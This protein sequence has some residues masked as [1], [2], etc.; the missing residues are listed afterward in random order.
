MVAFIFLPGLWS[1]EC[2]QGVVNNTNSNPDLNPHSQHAFLLPS[3]KIQIEANLSRCVASLQ[4]SWRFPGTQEG[5]G[6]STLSSEVPAGSDLLMIKKTQSWVVV[7]E[8]KPD[9]IK[10][11]SKDRRGSQCRGR[12]HWTQWTQVN[13]PAKKQGTG[14]VPKCLWEGIF[15][16]SR[17]G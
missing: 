10:R 6:A 15:A 7:G 16:P 9:W 3:L 8:V 13:C 4:S 11:Q 14:S 12:Q 2:A 17:S 5:K 1:K